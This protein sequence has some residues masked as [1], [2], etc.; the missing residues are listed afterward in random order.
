MMWLL[1]A[2][3]LVS[4]IP[5]LILGRYAV[6]AKDDYS[7]SVES[8]QYYKE[9]G[10]PLDAVRGAFDQARESYQ[11][12]QGTF[13][14]IFLMALQPAVFGFSFYRITAALMIA[15]FLAGTFLFCHVLFTD[16]FLE[17]KQLGV[18]VASLVSLIGLQLMLSPA[19]GLYWYNGAVYYTFFYGIGL[20]AMAG[21]IR[22]I[23][24]GG[25]TRMTLLCL[26]GIF[27]GG[28]NYM[29]ALCYALVGA[30]LL[31][32]AILRK[33]RTW[34]MGFPPYM[35]FFA[36]FAANAMAPGNAVRKLGMQLFEHPMGPAAAILASFKA[37]LNY[38]A[39]WFRLPVLAMML[40]LAGILLG[41]SVQKE[42]TGEFPFRFPV[43]LTVGSF[44]LF[45]A[46]FCPSFFSIGNEGPL[47]LLNAIWFSYV[48][49]LAVN[50]YYWIGWATKKLQ[51][52]KQKAENQENQSLVCEIGEKDERNSKHREKTGGCAG[53][54]LPLL[55]IT[56]G[57]LCCGFYVLR[58]G[59]YAS[60]AAI[61][62]I[63]SGEAQ[64]YYTAAEERL[65]VLEDPAIEDA[66]LE[67]YPCA[68]FMLYTDDISSN[69]LYFVNEDMAR[70]YGK[71]SVI[72]KSAG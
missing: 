17:K 37:G 59:S 69:R 38:G 25:W 57:L 51:H 71:K 41:H 56:L 54:K 14:A 34:W 33:E 5:L 27:L 19:E 29:T 11:T 50:T 6:P 47:R 15:A 43:L 26:L 28:G 4:L 65:A 10:N 67:P 61:G 58:L 72:R 9:T 7:F 16:V 2:A 20:I 48:L 39:Q 12:W 31:F 24:R 1:L 22:V 45:S 66:E 60:I 36:A 64:A 40:V 35:L 13:S 8:H 63:R 30:G 18:S 32:L 42:A 55:G 44:C 46:L 70:F 52:R 49:L 53:V 21:L 62:A 23:N 3:L 68:P